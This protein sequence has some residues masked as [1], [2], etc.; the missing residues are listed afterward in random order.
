MVCWVR[1]PV[2]IELFNCHVAASED[3]PGGASL[4][5]PCRTSKPYNTILLYLVLCMRTPCIFNGNKS[6]G[7]SVGSASPLH[8]ECQYQYQH[9]DLVASNT[10]SDNTS[11]VVL[12][13]ETQGLAFNRA[14]HYLR[15]T[16]ANPLDRS[17]NHSTPRTAPATAKQSDNLSHNEYPTIKEEIKTIFKEEKK[18]MESKPPPVEVRG[19]AVSRQSSRTEREL[20]VVIPS[21]D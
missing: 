6:I 14:T 3:Q 11:S 5:T 21:S 16:T 2:T 4:G 17:S 7:L 19:K 10:R 12:L 20:S 15:L 1:D 13:Q 8:T 18:V 9:L